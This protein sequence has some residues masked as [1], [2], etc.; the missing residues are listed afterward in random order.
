[1]LLKSPYFGS[2]LHNWSMDVWSHNKIS[3]VSPCFTWKWRLNHGHVPH[4]SSIYR[5]ILPNKNHPAIGLNLKSWSTTI[6][7]YSWYPHDEKG[8]PRRMASCRSGASRV[9]LSLRARICRN[10]TV[11]GTQ[12]GL[13][14]WYDDEIERHF[15]D[16][17]DFL[18]IVMILMWPWFY[19]F[20]G[21][22]L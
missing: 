13:L 16:C 9:W 1:M 5:W 3:S 17:N 20:Y 6:S 4:W 19:G 22:K 15:W 21:G 12:L 8:D 11:P 7:H 10:T 14:R 2:N 18:G